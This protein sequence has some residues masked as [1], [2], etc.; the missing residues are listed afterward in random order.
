MLRED[1]RPDV[2]NQ[3]GVDETDLPIVARLTDPMKLPPEVQQLARAE[4]EFDDG[5]TGNITLIYPVQS[6]WGV[7]EILGDKIRGVWRRQT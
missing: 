5:Q 4:V 6:P 3:V 7:H 2:V 1:T